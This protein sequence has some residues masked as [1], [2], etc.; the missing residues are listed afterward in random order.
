MVE[1]F[2]LLYFLINEVFVCIDKIFSDQEDV[3]NVEVLLLEVK[4]FREWEL[5]R[6]N[7]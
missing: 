2:T 1:F 7:I 6:V 3:C 4:V 5:E